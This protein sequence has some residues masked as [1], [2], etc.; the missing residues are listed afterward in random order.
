MVFIAKS[1]KKRFM[2][3]NTGLMISI[4]GVSDPELHSSG[5][6]PATFFWAQSLLGGHNVCLGGHKQ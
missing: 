4:L 1:T 5:T 6:E 2:S 3:T